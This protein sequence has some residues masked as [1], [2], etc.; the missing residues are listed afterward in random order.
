MS[1]ELPI[2]ALR[3]QFLEEIALRPV[4]ITAPTG[5][6]KS[7]QVP[8]WLFRETGAATRG[9]II[10]VQPRRVAARA[11][12]ARIAELEGV[13]LGKEVGYRV[14]DDDC[15]S[16]ATRLLVATPGILLARPA[17][18]S[19]ASIVVLDELH[20][21]RL[22]TDLLLALLTKAGTPF[23]AMSATMDGQKVADAVGGTH[24]HVATRNYP[25]TIEYYDTSADL[26]SSRDLEKRVKNA[27][28]RLPSRAGDVL[29][30][31]PGKGEIERIGGA[32]GTEEGEVIPLHGGLGLKEQSRALGSSAKRR[33]ILSTNVAETSLTI[34][35]VRAVIDSGLVRRTNY[36]NGRTYLTLANVALDSADQRAGRAGRTA[37]GH[38]VRL[39]GSQ[40]R[41]GPV[42]P[43][44]IHRE[45]LGPLVM[46][47][48]LLEVAPAAL[49]FLDSPKDYALLN[50]QNRLIELGVV[51]AEPGETA[52]RLTEIGRQLLGFPLD[53]WLS[54]VLIE[55]KKTGCLDDAIDLVALLE[56]P[57][58]SALSR[59]APDEELAHHACDA[60]ALVYMLREGQTDSPT[61][62]QAL[63]EARSTAKRLR[64]AFGL[65]G[66]SPRGGITDR[67]LL[68]RTL[69]LADPVCAHVARPRKN[70]IAFSNGG[71]EM[72]VGRDSRVNR[73]LTSLNPVDKVDALVVLETHGMSAGADHKLFIT[74]A[75]PIPLSLLAEARLG[76][77]SVK[78]AKI[79]KTEPFRGK[80]IVTLERIYAGRLLR[81]TEEEPEGLHARQAVVELFVKGAL[82]PAMRKEAAR[83]LARRSLAHSLG[84]HPDF[85]HFKSCAEAPLLADWLLG[86]L[87]ELGV[88]SGDDLALLSPS[89]FLPPDVPAELAPQ[90]DERFP[91]EVDVGDCLYRVEYDL[92]KRQATLSILRGARQ[93]PPP[94]NYLPRFEGLRVF[95]EAGGSF[96]PVRR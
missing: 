9:L 28:S 72:G 1:R 76:N 41:L 26:P 60:E 31:L 38:C 59:S 58:A 48:A 94:P 21:R 27:L 20:E 73:M 79:S 32:L 5:T 35:G 93:K 81:T 23:V 44:E 12:A 61:E 17:L 8:R 6:G 71:T 49:P 83:R 2:E 15:S 13:A 77:V 14:R 25:V 46:T 67:K 40:A 37:P 29:V 43:P 55:A 87:G 24:L 16:Q 91:L 65:E 85:P 10:V 4:V 33:I 18:L 36:H 78:E 53:P 11:V 66:S 69:L 39:W 88:E 64:Q 95:V 47:C 54:R 52:P 34:P 56:Q 57:H 92:K 7:T 19:D 51:R 22:D 89:D 45:D 74:L 80:V 70:G 50:A 62:R 42:T 96:H 75:S 86:H 68:L 63:R 90:L 82:H 84:Q 3:E 30:F